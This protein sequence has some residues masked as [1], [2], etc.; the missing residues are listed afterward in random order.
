CMTD[1][2]C[3]DRRAVPSTVPVAFS[4]WGGAHP[5]EERWG[6]R[7]RL[8]QLAGGPIEAAELRHDCS[9]ITSPWTHPVRLPPRTDQWHTPVGPAR[10]VRPSSDP[11]SAGLPARSGPVG[12]TGAG[13]APSDP[14]EQA[15]PRRTRR[16][17]LG[18][19]RPD[20]GN[21]HADQPRSG[22]AAPSI[23]R[24]SS[25]SPS[26]STGTLGRRRVSGVTR[27]LCSSSGGPANREIWVPLSTY[28]QA[29]ETPNEEA[30]PT[31]AA[32]SARVAPKWPKANTSIA[33]RISVPYPRPCWSRVSQEPESMALRCAK[34]VAMASWQPISRPSAQMPNGSVHCSAER[35]ARSRH[36]KRRA[37]RTRCSGSTAY[38]GKT[39]SASASSKIGRRMSSAYSGRSASVSTRNVSDPARITSPW[40]GNSAERPGVGSI[41][42]G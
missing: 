13:P 42:P 22:Q 19:G 9:S 11:R 21:A 8:E 10:S 2:T 30:L 37:S 25:L 36:W 38:Q 32:D 17:R 12:P 14:P 26:T 34:R 5:G 31:A 16:A 24:S 33:W 7:G 4:K 3:P 35:S 29:R 28:P 39:Y 23:S 15:R 18:T 1:L 40:G 41:A 6:P 27:N 20:T